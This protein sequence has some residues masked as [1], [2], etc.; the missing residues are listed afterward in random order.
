MIKERGINLINKDGK[1]N[2]GTYN[3]RINNMNPLDLKS[4]PWRFAPKKFKNSRLKEW[5]AY[6]V[7][8]KDHYVLIAAMNLKH[9]SILKVLLHNKETNQSWGTS[10]ILP[11]HS[12]LVSQN[13]NC[14]T[15]NV[16]DQETIIHASHFLDQSKLELGFAFNDELSGEKISGYLKS[17]D[18]LSEPQVSILPLKNAGGLYT[19]KQLISMCG[20]LMIGGQIVRVSDGDACMIIDDQKAFY[21]YI[22]KWDW[23]TAS[24][25]RD[26]RYM[27]F[28]L[29]DVKA[30][31]SNYNENGFWKNDKHYKV[32]NVRFCRNKASG[33]WTIVDEQGRVNVVFRPVTKHIIKRNFGLASANYEGPLGWYSGYLTSEC[34]EKLHVNGMFG[35]GEKMNLRL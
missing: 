20:H 10:K 1:Y 26:G 17:G 6:M 14:D 3:K 30:V 15:L 29:S 21:P 13:M 31:K 16:R 19:H 34:G 24:G 11:F 9:V 22:T 8:T 18:S 5:H 23:A 12:V 27:G 33:S 35:M 25:V 7:G 32:P 28:T 4:F 2:F